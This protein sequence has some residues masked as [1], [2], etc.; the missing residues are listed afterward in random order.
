M[1]AEGEVIKME[2]EPLSP[3]ARLFHTPRLNYCIIAILG[4]KTMIGVKV[5]KIGLE[6]SL[7]KHPRFCNVLDFFRL[8]DHAS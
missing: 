7:I 5:F 3:G 1:A 2:E 6:Q 4:S 8:P